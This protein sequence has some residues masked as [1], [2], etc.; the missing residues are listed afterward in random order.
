MV[1]V[2]DAAALL[3]LARRSLLPRLPRLPF[4]VAVADALHAD[5]RFDLNGI[6]WPRLRRLGVRVQG[7]D[8]DGVAVAI[9][10]QN[11]WPMLSS[12]D[13]FT[14]ALALRRS[15]PLL[16]HHGCVSAA[17]AA[18]GVAVRDLR[19][20]GRRLAEASATTAPPHAAVG[21]ATAC[22]A[23]RCRWHVDG[24]TD[25]RYRCPVCPPPAHCADG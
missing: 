12:H 3:E 23:L 22:P 14:V 6:D 25:C 17:A 11:D 7:L 15:W 24:G 21:M 2:C 9:A 18:H 10:C 16:T 19:W 4:G 20:L 13:C 1:L 5:P 8:A